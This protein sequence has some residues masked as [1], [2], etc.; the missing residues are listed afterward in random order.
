MLDGGIVTNET[1]AMLGFYTS[2]TDKER[3]IVLKDKLNEGSYE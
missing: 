2:K 1:I 3:V